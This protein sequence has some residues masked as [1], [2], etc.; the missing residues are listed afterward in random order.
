MTDL[1][2]L[3][4]SRKVALGDV[5]REAMKDKGI[6]TR[7][8]CARIGG[9]CRRQAIQSILSGRVEPTLEMLQRICTALDEV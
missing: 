9:N 2:T 1:S 8:L 7:E 5:L 6:G 3:T 4:A